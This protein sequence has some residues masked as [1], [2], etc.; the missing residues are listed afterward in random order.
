MGDAVEISEYL[1]NEQEWPST[2]RW[3]GDAIL[4]L[5]DGNRVPM[6]R[7]LRERHNLASVIDSFPAAAIITIVVDDHQSASALE[8]VMYC[9]EG[10]LPAY[11][12]ETPDQF[13]LRREG[14]LLVIKWKDA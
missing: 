4:A 11:A 13:S 14:A 10:F 2:E 9:K 8:D 3:E 6:D 1:P 7:L 12:H 5:L